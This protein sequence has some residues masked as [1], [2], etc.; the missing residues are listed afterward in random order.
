MTTA[1]EPLSEPRNGEDA[2]FF[3]ERNEETDGV[4]G[5]L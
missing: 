4:V 2:A 1:S 5:K 3:D